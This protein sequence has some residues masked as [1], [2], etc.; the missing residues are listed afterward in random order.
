VH[1]YDPHWF[2]ETHPED[3]TTRFGRGAAALAARRPGEQ[4]DLYDGEIRFT[5][6]YFARLI[7]HLKALGLYDRTILVVTGDHG[8]GFGEHGIDFHGYH[9]YNPQ[10][11]VPFLVRVPGLGAQRPREPVGH[12]DLHPTL[13]NLIRAAPEPRFEGRSFVDLLTTGGG[14]ARHIFQEVMYEGPTVRKTV[15]TADWKLVNNAVPDQTFELYRVSTDPY[16][17]RDLW[18]ATDTAAIGAELRRELSAWM[19]EEDVP[20]DWHARVDPAVRHPGQPRFVAPQPL[21][22]RFGDALRLY[23]YDLKSATV[24]RGEALD[25]TWYLEARARLKGPWRLFVHL[26]GP[27]FINA[28]HDPVEGL[29]PLRHFARG[30]TVADHQKIALPWHLRPGTYTVYLGVFAGRDR[31]PVS[32]AGA[33]PRQQ[34]AAA[35]T[36]TIVP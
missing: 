21:D 31:L 28:D 18:G 23:G 30:M 35:L 6:N 2:Y 10:T 14:P 22:V 25:V 7:A 1:Y 12:I 27:G 3:P 5:D 36:F 32:G 19:E 11:K 24:R 9:L 20:P 13:L 16:E 17:T 8:E 33:D 29:L 15:V 4:V 26:V 34:R